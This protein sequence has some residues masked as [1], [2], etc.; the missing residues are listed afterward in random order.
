MRRLS[1]TASPAR[2]LRQPRQHQ[3]IA[4]QPALLGI[5]EGMALGEVP[6]AELRIEA[7]QVL[8]D[9]ARLFELA[10]GGQA[11]RD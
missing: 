4:E 11:R 6:G 10:A 7:Q 9:L 2:L 1:G 8:G 3:M 5:P